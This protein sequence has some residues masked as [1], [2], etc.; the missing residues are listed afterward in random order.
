MRASTIF[1]DAQAAII[2]M[3]TWEVGLGQ[4]CALQ[5]RNALTKNDEKLRPTK[6]RTDG[7]RSPPASRTVTAS[8]AVTAGRRRMPLPAPLAHLKRRIRKSGRNAQEWSIAGSRT[9][10]LTRNVL[11]KP[12]TL[13]PQRRQSA[14]QTALTATQMK[15]I[16]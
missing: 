8:S 1:G 11:N 7:Q 3:Q 9:A 12:P 4:H 14:L 16:R 6:L 15:T 5:A 10:G 13:Y 2:R